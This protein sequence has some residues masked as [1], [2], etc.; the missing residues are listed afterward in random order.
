MKLNDLSDKVVKAIWP[1]PDRDKIY[2]AFTDDTV[3]YIYRD[4]ANYSELHL[5]RTVKKEKV[6]IEEITETID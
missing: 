2:I 3:I 4:E 1:S 5:G 6:I